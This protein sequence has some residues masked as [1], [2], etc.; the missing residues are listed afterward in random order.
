MELLPLRTNPHTGELWEIPYVVYTAGTE[1]QQPIARVEGFSAHHL[2]VTISGKGRFRPIGGGEEWDLIE[3]GTLLFIP[4]GFGHEYT[5]Y[6]EH[7]WHVAYVTFTTTAAASGTAA[8]DTSWGFGREPSLRPLRQTDRLLRLIAGIWARMKA[9]VDSWATA[10]LLYAFLVE[11]RKQVVVD[12]KSAPGRKVS[13]PYTVVQRAATFMQDHME[14][15]LA[16]ADVAE[17]FGYSPKQLTRLFRQTYRTTPLQYWKRI[18]LQTAAALLDSGMSLAQI[19]A[20]I[21]MEPVYFSRAFRAQYACTPSE[22]R[23]RLRQ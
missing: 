20:R 2:I 19:A 18:R 14:R 4:A 3:A 15:S 16:V 6:G 11:T 22:F 7:P 8:A 10:E 1:Y 23:E 21:G 12:G 13:G 5:P 9:P 17:R